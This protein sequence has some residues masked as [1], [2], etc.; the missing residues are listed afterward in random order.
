MESTDPRTSFHFVS[1]SS[2]QVAVHLPTSRDPL[3]FLRRNATGS[4]LHFPQVPPRALFLTALGPRPTCPRRHTPQNASSVSQNAISKT[5]TWAQ[6]SSVQTVVSWFHATTHVLISVARVC[7]GPTPSAQGVIAKVL[8]TSS[9][10][11][12]VTSFAPH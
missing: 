4:T 5:A 11:Y 8:K 10:C 3:S 6:K 1:F 9:V 7:P 2:S 12:M